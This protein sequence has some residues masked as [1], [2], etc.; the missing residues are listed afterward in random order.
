MEKGVKTPEELIQNDPPLN[1]DLNSGLL[2]LEPPAQEG[3]LNNLVTPSPPA[4]M[5]FFED[6]YGFGK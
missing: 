4:G 5:D 2:D 1:P 3:S 6:M